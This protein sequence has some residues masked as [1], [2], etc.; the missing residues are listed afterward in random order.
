[1]GN[2]YSQQTRGEPKGNCGCHR[3]KKTGHKS[4]FDIEQFI[5]KW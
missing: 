5:G 1:M 4:N 3:C 2:D